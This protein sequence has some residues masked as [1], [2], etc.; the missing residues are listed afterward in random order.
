M[1]THYSGVGDTS[2]E[3]PETQDL[4]TDSQDNFQDENIVQQLIHETEGLK[5]AVEDRDND[6]RDAIH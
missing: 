4:D 6:P 2:I 1:A 5:Q 3:N